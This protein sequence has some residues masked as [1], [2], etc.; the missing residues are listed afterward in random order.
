MKAIQLE[1]PKQ[2][3]R[4][5]RAGSGATRRW[6]GAGARASH[7]HLRY[8]LQRLISARCRSILIREFLVTNSGVEVLAVARGEKCH[9]RRPLFRRAV[10]ELSAVLSM[11]ARQRELLRTIESA[12]RDDRWRN[13]RALIVPARKLHKSEKLSFD[14]LALVETLASDVMR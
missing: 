3:R 12:W 1:Q 8:G 6:R 7:W 11:P 10:H 9:G 5:G 2:F 14:Q 4:I 13:A